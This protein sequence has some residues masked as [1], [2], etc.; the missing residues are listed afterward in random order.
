MKV[1]DMMVIS[2][3]ISSPVLAGDKY[4][5]SEEDLKLPNVTVKLTNEQIDLLKSSQLMGLY[6]GMTMTEIS[7]FYQVDP[8][9]VEADSGWH[10]L[11]DRD[12]SRVGVARALYSLSS[13]LDQRV[14]SIAFEID[15]WPTFRAVFASNIEGYH[16]F[17]ELI[18]RQKTSSHRYPVLYR[19]D[20]K[21][22]RPT[23]EKLNSQLNQHINRSR[24]IYQTR[25]AV[26]ERFGVD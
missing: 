22:M 15:S 26:E 3:L 12:F 7:H 18:V 20:L 24:E 8:S 5:Q 2:L 14:N 1:L 23:D 21:E 17:D 25:Q 13:E 19:M 4:I 16:P 9:T 6:P 10:S 11:Y